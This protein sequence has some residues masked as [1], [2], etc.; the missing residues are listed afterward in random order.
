MPRMV[1]KLALLVIAPGGA[2]KK[3]KRYYENTKKPATSDSSLNTKFIFFLSFLTIVLLSSKKSCEKVDNNH[4]SKGTF[5]TNTQSL[6]LYGLGIY[7]FSVSLYLIRNSNLFLC[8]EVFFA[9]FI[10]CKVN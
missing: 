4:N 9:S 6:R 2:R 10:F 3:E 5:I 1:R 7:V 8:K